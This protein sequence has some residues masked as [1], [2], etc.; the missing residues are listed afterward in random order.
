MIYM[1]IYFFQYLVWEKITTSMI[2]CKRYL[3]IASL[4]S[5]KERMMKSISKKFYRKKINNK[6][7]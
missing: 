5:K 4:R 6:A 2:I 7:P 1:E 3:D